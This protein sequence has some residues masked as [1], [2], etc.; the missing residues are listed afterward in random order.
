MI[1]TP[2]LQRAVKSKDAND[3][4]ILHVMDKIVLC[5]FQSLQ[6]LG[7]PHATTVSSKRNDASF[8]I[9]Q[10]QFTSNDGVGLNFSTQTSNYSKETN[11]S[12]K[13]LVPISCGEGGGEYKILVRGLNPRNGLCVGRLT[14]LLSFNLLRSMETGIQLEILYDFIHWIL[15]RTMIHFVAITTSKDTT[16]IVCCC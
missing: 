5:I 8:A 15:C 12:G 16:T 11:G 14:V 3:N 4:K 10:N 7:C 9:F 1:M 2:S 6:E 13:S